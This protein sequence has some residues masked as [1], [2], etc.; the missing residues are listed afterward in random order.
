MV[1]GL[2]VFFCG[3]VHGYSLIE[4]VCDELLVG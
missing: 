1:G 2:N 4:F 3:F